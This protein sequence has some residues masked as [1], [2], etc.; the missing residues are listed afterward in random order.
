M[1]L[2][3]VRTS[4][5]LNAV[6]VRAAGSVFDTGYTD[7]LAFINGG[8]AALEAAINSITIGHELEV[9]RVLAPILRPPKM[10]FSG[11]NYGSHINENSAAIFPEEPF[12]FAKLSSAIVGDYDDI[13]LPAADL[14][15]DWEVEL[16]LVIGKVA[17]NLSMQDALDCVFGY[18]VVNDVSARVIQFKDQQITVGKNLDTYCPMGPEIVTADEIGDLGTLVLRS[19]VNGEKMQDS[20][21]QDMLFNPAKLLVHLTALMT[22]EPGDVVSTGT[23]AGVG[24][25]RI[26]PR[27]LRAG[28]EVVVEVDR[29]GKLTNRVIA[30]V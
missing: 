27:Y 28:D 22:L 1:R 17:R 4:N 11:M 24:T 2:L 23:P 9:E 12:F 29:I 30:G 21:T 16:A 7:M 10:L 18:T 8:D 19:F 13:V 14:E 15:S 5:A 6:G 25:F 26:P 3:T 20:S